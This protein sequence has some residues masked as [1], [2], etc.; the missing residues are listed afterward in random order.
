MSQIFKSNFKDIKLEPPTRKDK[1]FSALVCGSRINF[2][3]ANSSKQFVYS[4][5][6]KARK[7]YYSRHYNLRKKYV[8]DAK[9]KNIQNMEKQRVKYCKATPR[10]LSTL[11]LW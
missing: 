11:F 5:S 7:A 9:I 4:G 3:D 8:T 2:G 10:T 6:T 1:K